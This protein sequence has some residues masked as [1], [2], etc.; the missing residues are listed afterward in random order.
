MLRPE[1]IAEP[2]THQRRAFKVG[3]ERHQA[4]DRGFPIGRV[5]PLSTIDGLRRSKPEF[6]AHLGRRVAEL[7][8]AGDDVDRA[9]P[10]RQAWRGT[11]NLE[12]QLRQAIAV[13]GKRQPLEHHI[14]QPLERRNLAGLLLGDDQRIGLLI[15]GARVGP[16]RKARQI[17]F[18]AIGPDAADEAYRSLAKSDRDIGE[19][20]VAHGAA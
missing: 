12:G 13:A 14:S 16:H 15:L 6:L 9:E 18:L 7:G 10:L 20:A 11:H 19:I 17:E 2:G 3:R 5:R 4:V 1:I 8:R